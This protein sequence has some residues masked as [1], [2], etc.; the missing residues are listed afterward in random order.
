MSSVVIAPARPLGPAPVEQEPRGAS[1]PRL[2][3]SSRAYL[4]ACSVAALAVVLVGI[5]WAS[6]WGG[7]NFAGSMRSLRVVLAGPADPVDHRGPPRRRAGPTG[8]AAATLCPRLP[9]GP[10][11]H[12][13]QRDPRR[14][15]GDRAHALLRGGGPSIPSVARLDQIRYGAALGRHRGDLRGHGRIEL[16]RPSGQ[17]PCPSALAV[18]RAPSL[19]GGHECADGVSYASPDSRVLP[20]RLASRDRP[21]GQRCVAHHAARR[22]RGGRRLRPLEHQSGLRSARTDLRQSELPPDPSPVGWTPGCQ[23]RL[24]AHHLGPAVRPGGVPHR[25]DHQDRHRAPGSAAGRRTGRRSTPPSLG[26]RR[27]A[28]R[29][30][31]PDE[32]PHRPPS[33]QSGTSSAG[34]SSCSILEPL[35]AARGARATTERGLD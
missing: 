1:R 14:A 29:S 26:L 32:R 16:V 9:P 13:V 10:P 24:R 7:A 30:V 27:S 35:G 6:H 25:S 18:P 33:R 28:G 4:P 20:H 15:A 22:L 5:G 17:S 8:P 21:R 11:L 2:A 31:P 3:L 19:A 12:G 34:S 23:P